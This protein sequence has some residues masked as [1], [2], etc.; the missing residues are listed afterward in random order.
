MTK[1]LMLKTEFRCWWRLLIVGGRRLCKKIVDVGDKNGQNRHEHIS[2]PTSVTNI[3]VT[4]RFGYWIQYFWTFYPDEW[5]NDI[6][7]QG[8]FIDLI[9]FFKWWF[10]ESRPIS[11]SDKQNCPRI[12]EIPKTRPAMWPSNQLVLKLFIYLYAIS[13]SFL[14]TLK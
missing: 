7:N 13:V 3:D 12:H 11:T 2:S 5:K 6:Q 8:I 1:F 4:V 10:L 9:W 14:N